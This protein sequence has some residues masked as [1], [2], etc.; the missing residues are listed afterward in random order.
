MRFSTADEVK[1]DA[2]NMNRNQSIIFVKYLENKGAVI[3]SFDISERGKIVLHKTFFNKIKV[4]RFKNLPTITKPLEGGISS[5]SPKANASADGHLPVLKGICNV[6]NFLA[7]VNHSSVSKVVDENGEPLV[8]YHVSR[9]S[10]S[11]FRFNYAIFL[12]NAG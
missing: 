3:V 4:G 7:P 1:L 12:A 11:E 9:H 10:F 2:A 5:I 6:P 8:V